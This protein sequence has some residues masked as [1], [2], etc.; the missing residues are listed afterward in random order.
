MW[1]A[2]A[3]I[4]AWV[5][6]SIIAACRG[7]DSAKRFFNSPPLAAFWLGLTLL[8]TIGLVVYPRLRQNAGSLLIHAGTVFILI[9]AMWG[10]PQGHAVQKRLF[11]VDKIPAGYMMIPRQQAENQIFDEEF[12]HSL[13]DLPFDVYLHDFRIDYYSRLMV[14]AADGTKITVEAQ[15]G[16]QII[17]GPGQPVIKILRVFKNFKINID[18][19]NRDAVDDP[20]SGANPALQIELAWPDGKTEKKYI[21]ERFPEFGPIPG[22]LKLRYLLMP[23]DYFSD[24]EIRSGDQTVLRKTIEVNSPLHYGGYNFYQSSYDP[25]RGQYTILS[26]TSDTGRTTVFA[27]FAL[28]QLGLCWHFWRRLKPPASENLA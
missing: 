26:V 3:A 10:S 19:P 18:G 4:V 20:K 2:L 6:L 17:P 16:R 5:A 1:I 8:L 7:A 12:K 27:G 24:L 28:V 14:Q 21:Y 23:K 25:E 13:A 11:G 9:G 15:P 22:G